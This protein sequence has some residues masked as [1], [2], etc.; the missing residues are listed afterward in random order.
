M[1]TYVRVL[2]LSIFSSAHCPYIGVQREHAP[3]R[4]AARML[5]QG[6]TA[7]MTPSQSGETL[8]NH[9][10]FFFIPTERVG[11]FYVGCDA[12]I[13][14]LRRITA[15]ELIGRRSLCKRD[16]GGSGISAVNER[17]RKIRQTKKLFFK[18]QRCC[19]DSSCHA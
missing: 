15:Y 9:R 6:K 5:R 18:D 11:D 7:L 2:T 12:H 16:G 14:C 1:R 13:A 17:K 8:I 3:G 19:K 4:T 10:R